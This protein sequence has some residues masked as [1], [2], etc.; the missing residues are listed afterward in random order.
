MA[1]QDQA[2]TVDD[3]FALSDTASMSE[4]TVHHYGH[5]NA[6]CATDV[7]GHKEPRGASREEIVIDN[8]EGFIPLWGPNVILRWRLDVNSLKRFKDP[9]AAAMGIRQLMGKALTAWGD[10]VPVKFVERNDA[11][12]FEVTVRESDRCSS[13]GCVLASAFFPDAGRHELKIYPQFFAQ[14][15]TEQ[16]ET[17]VH[18]F[19]HVFGLRHFFAL[20]SEQQWPAVVYG[21]HKPFTIMNYGDKSVLTEAD[22]RDLRNLYK[23]VW[24]GE[25][26]EINGT[27]IRL[28]RPYHE[29]AGIAFETGVIAAHTVL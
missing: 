18:E 27:P 7:R 3:V 5:S 9:E 13:N 2:I 17:M 25:L 20:V 26:K 24:S 22:V 15:A 19:G 4:P 8:T 1:P 10:A 21:E 28:M 12:D 14:S 29:S 6:V 23:A 11:F 16:I